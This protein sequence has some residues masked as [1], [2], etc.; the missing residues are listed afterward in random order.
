MVSDD[1]MRALRLAATLV[2]ALPGVRVR[3]RDGDRAVVDVAPADAPAE[4]G[5]AVATT[6]CGFRRAVVGA[7]DA[8]RGGERVGLLGVAV[9][10]AVDVG[11]RR[12]GRMHPGGVHEVVCGDRRV[13]AIATTLGVRA[14]HDE[15]EALVPAEALAPGV[16]G[17]GLRPD[18]ATGVCLAYA[19]LPI[20]APADHD[21]TT[22]ALLQE[23]RARFVVRELLDDLADST[24]SR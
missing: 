1:G 8:H 18:E 2:H 7:W 17:I 16:W 15:A 11:I 12:P 22:V 23:L 5:V 4:P 24:A 20:T 3:L 13:F 14:C 6:P 19:E 21:T 9:D 10:P